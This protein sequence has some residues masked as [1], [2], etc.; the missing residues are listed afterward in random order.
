MTLHFILMNTLVSSV[1]LIRIFLSDGLH[2][3]KSVVHISKI[4]NKAY[5]EHVFILIHVISS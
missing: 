3:L 2:Y 1:P 4:S 5:K